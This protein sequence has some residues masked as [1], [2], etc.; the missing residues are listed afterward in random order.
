M[1]LLDTLKISSL[2]F[3]KF[4]YP[5][6]VTCDFDLKTYSFQGKLLIIDRFC[7]RASDFCNLELFNVKMVKNGKYL[8]A[9]VT[10]NSLVPFIV[11][12]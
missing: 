8:T 6:F 9:V 5:L 7:M 1:F 11:Q 3:S 10:L 2:T 12:T 4:S